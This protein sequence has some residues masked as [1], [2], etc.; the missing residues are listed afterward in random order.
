MQSEIDRLQDEID[1]KKKELKEQGKQLCSAAEQL[2]SV[3][4]ELATRQEENAILTRTVKNL[5]ETIS[6]QEDAAASLQGQVA[7]LEKRLAAEVEKQQVLEER[8]KNVEEKMEEEKQRASQ[9]VKQLEEA[10]QEAKTKTLL[11]LEMRDYELTVE[12]LNGQLT[13]KNLRITSLESEVEREKGR[14]SNLQEQLVHLI[15]QEATERERAEEMKKLL[16]EQKT[17]LAELHQIQEKESS[18]RQLDRSTMEQLTQE[19]EKQKLMVAEISS[20]KTKYED[21]L[22]HTKSTMERQIEILE[23][24]VSHHKEEIQQLVAERDSL[25][26]EFEGYKVRAASV[27]R[28]KNRPS[29]IN[30]EDLQSEKDQLQ[31]ECAA[32]QLKLQQ[33]QSDFSAMKAENSFLQSEKEGMSKQLISLSEDLTRKEK[34]YQKKMSD[35]ESKMEAEIKEHQSMISALSAQNETQKVTFKKQFESLRQ[36]HSHEVEELITKLE[37]AEEKLWNQKNSVTGPAPALSASLSPGAPAVLPQPVRSEVEHVPGAVPSGPTHRRQPSHGYE[38]SRIDVSNMVREDGEGSE[39]VEPVQRSPSKVGS[40]SPPPL[41]QL[42]SAPLPP[43]APLPQDDQISITSAATDAANRELTRLEVKISAAETRI[44]QVTSLL[45]ESE[46][47]NAKLTQLSD[48]LKEEIRRAAR[49][50]DREKH[51]ENMEYM[52]NVILK[53]LLLGNGEERKHLVPVLKTVL[54]LSPQEASQL[55]HIA[56]GEEGDAAA[57]TGWGN[58]LHLWS[59]R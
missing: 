37:E 42:I 35:L 7:A 55:E 46:A 31:S 24:Q 25:H 2:A 14:S 36:T 4:S 47:E 56:T 28:Q 6:S 21:L 30:V 43:A 49:N 32:A 23:E 53:F 39:W 40:Y 19:V 13:E 34:F 27:L 45:H 44:A 52:K 10:K 22:R 59:S 51:M 38:E 15:T 54:Q 8:R 3:R 48:A 5:E 41:E 50:E 12:E 57:R 17:E 29:E 1:N 9:Y 26:T 33:L 20:E 11:D 58:Y 18:A 16:L